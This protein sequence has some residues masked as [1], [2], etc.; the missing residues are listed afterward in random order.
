MAQDRFR[1]DYDLVAKYEY[2]SWE[3]WEE[4]DDT[5]VFNSNDNGD[6][7]H[8]KA[9]GKKET[10]RKVV[11]KDEGYTD[12]GKHYQIIAI[13]DEDGMKMLL[14]YFDDSTIGIKLILSS[15]FMIQFAKKE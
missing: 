9:S 13:L 2:G 15:D 1:V 5:V 6:I 3:G 11:K 10:Y 4:D 14:P 7:I 12:S 8:Y